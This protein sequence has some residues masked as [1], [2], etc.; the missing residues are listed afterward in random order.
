MRLIIEGMGYASIRSTKVYLKVG[1]IYF[2]LYLKY[3]A[4][5]TYTAPLSSVFHD[6]WDSNSL[7]AESEFA[8]IPVVHATCEEVAVTLFLSLTWSHFWCTTTPYSKQS[9][10]PHFLTS[11]N[12][13]TLS[14]T[15]SLTRTL[16]CMPF[17]VPSTPLARRTFPVPLHPFGSSSSFPYPNRNIEVQRRNQEL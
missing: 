8:G 13:S 12:D 10:H 11:I 9:S 3:S 5:G 6:D 2:N 7:A 15:S 17:F 4:L 16:P 14:Q 1:G